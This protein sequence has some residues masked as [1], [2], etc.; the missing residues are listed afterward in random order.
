MLQR[1]SN[2]FPTMDIVHLL[3]GATVSS[4]PPPE[5]PVGPA[6]PPPRRTAHRRRALL[7]LVAAGLVVGLWWGSG[8]VVAYTDDAYVDSD[9]VQV[10][11]EVAGPIEAVHVTDNQWITRSTIL[12]TID[13]TPFRLQLQQAIANEEQAR[14]QLP[15]DKAAIE[16]LRAQK[17]A[18]DEAAR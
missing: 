3:G 8:Y 17:E 2:E 13:P 15:V 4:R 1:D 11:P 18:A 12:F 7:L 5:L 14:A 16:S 6:D 10:T 9:V